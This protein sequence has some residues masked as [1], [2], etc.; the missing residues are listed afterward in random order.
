MGMLF[1]LC[2]TTVGGAARGTEWQNLKYAAEGGDRHLYILNGFVT[3][4][5]TYLKSQSMLSHGTVVARS[6][7]P[8]VSVCLLLMLTMVYPAAAVM[9][10]QIGQPDLG[11]NYRY[12]I[13]IK[14][15]AVMKSKDYT[16][17]L[18]F[19]TENYLG[20]SM[21][22]RTWRQFICTILWNVVGIRFDEDTEKNDDIQ[23]MHETFGH[24]ASMAEQH[25]AIQGTNALPYLS[26]QAVGRHQLVS[27]KWHSAMGQASTVA[28][29]A[30]VVI[31]TALSPPSPAPS[32]SEWKTELDMMKQQILTA[33]AH[34]P[35][36]PPL[37]RPQ[38]TTVQ[39]LSI[40]VHPSL[41]RCLAVVVPGSTAF[42]R[43]EQ[44]ELV[45]SVFT[46]DHVLAV[47]PTG[48]GKSMAFFGAASLCPESMFVVITPLVALTHDLVAR[49]KKTN[50]AG[51]LWQ[52]L[53]SDRSFRC[54]RDFHHM[55]LVIVSAHEAG[56]NDFVSWVISWKNRIKRIFFD[57]AHQIYTSHTFRPCFTHFQSLT[58]VGIPMTFL[59]ATVYPHSVPRLCESM[60][61]DISL[62][63]EIRT[64]TAR[65]NIRYSALHT[66]DVVGTI[67]S[68][69][70]ELDIRDRG[71]IYSTTIA[72]CQTIADLIGCD[73]F[74]SAIHD[75]VLENAA[76]K[77]AIE[78]RWRQ[79]KDPR[80][81]WLS[82][83]T[84]FGQGI[85]CA[86]VRKVY[87]AEVWNALEIAQQGGRAGRDGRAAEC[88]VVW[89]ELPRFKNEDDDGHLGVQDAHDFLQTKTCRRLVLGRFDEQAHSCASI[90]GAILCDCC[91]KLAEVRARIFI[92]MFN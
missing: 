43:P 26:H 21:G 80:H 92:T 59:S 72:M 68:E 74:I 49:L 38:L 35:P 15:G 50:M 69:V 45:Q 62:L 29:K 82:A 17:L 8:D 85:D 44:A 14:S 30:A 36:P 86:C 64:C 12:H 61:M 76:V 11:R 2:F 16:V 33:V 60:A 91:E 42:T 51:G 41:S 77:K 58:R 31:K 40:V 90:P 32:H 89:S 73:Y 18:R 56:T 22:L 53:Q 20:L 7:A 10:Q 84:S 52:E 1:F 46:G 3:I 87:I 9:M 66:D 71:I 54:T 70:T 81:R 39:K 19:Y 57:E 6:P 78:A 88:R 83:T 55:Q 65:P 4:V 23:A 28:S 13:F 63:R 79:G 75:D 34:R 48:S 37:P 24:S 47:M 27:L 5:T 25:Y 67:C